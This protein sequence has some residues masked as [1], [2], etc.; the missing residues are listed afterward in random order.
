VG[1]AHALSLS[2]RRGVSLPRERAFALLSSAIEEK[3]KLFV[4][5][6]IIIEN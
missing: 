3:P 1:Q 5:Y 4:K 6:Q 2:V